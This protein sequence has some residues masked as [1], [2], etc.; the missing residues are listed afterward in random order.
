[1][2]VVFAAKG[3]DLVETVLATIPKV[4]IERGVYPEDVL[5]ER[6]VKVTVASFS[7]QI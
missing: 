5:K 2:F 7:T 3:D 6:F 4:A 1:V